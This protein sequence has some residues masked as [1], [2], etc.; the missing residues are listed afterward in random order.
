MW[1]WVSSAGCADRPPACPLSGGFPPNSGFP[2]CSGVFVPPQSIFRDVLRGRLC[3]A[4]PMRGFGDRL[5]AQLCR[6]GPRSAQ[7]TSLVPSSLLFCSPAS[8][9]WRPAG[10]AASLAEGLPL[11]PRRVQVSGTGAGRQRACRGGAKLVT[12]R[13]A[14]CAGGRVPQLRLDRLAAPLSSSP[15]PLAA[16]P[17]AR[18]PPRRCRRCPQPALALFQVAGA[19][20][21]RLR[22]T[23]GGRPAAAAGAALGEGRRGGPLRVRAVLLP[24]LPGARRPALARGVGKKDA[25]CPTAR[26]DEERRCCRSPQGLVRLKSRCQGA[27]WQQRGG[28]WREKPNGGKRCLRR[29]SCPG[30]RLRVPGAGGSGEREAPQQLCGAVLP[31]H[32]ATPAL[33]LLA[34]TVAAL[35]GRGLKGGSV[36]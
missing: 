36:S 24:A 31:P 11:L 1:G 12:Q 28:R 10:R 27:R 14:V 6:Q 22:L 17:G 7:G 8:F 23:G 29:C 4:S 15:L 34:T 25:P 5:S 9:L 18:V 33:E 35:K 19:D 30:R 20:R 3:R 13:G 26:R 21:A 16:A 32:G 2:L